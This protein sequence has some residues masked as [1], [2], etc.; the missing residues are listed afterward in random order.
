MRKSTTTYTHIFNLTKRQKE[1]LDLLLQGCTSLEQIAE[2]MFIEKIT[3]RTHLNDIYSKLGIHSLA[4]LIAYL[5]KEKLN[6]L[7]E[8]NEEYKKRE[9][10]K[11]NLKKGK[12]I[13]YV[14]ISGNSFA[15]HLHYEVLKDGVYLDPVDFFYASVTPDEYANIKFMASR[16]GQSL[17]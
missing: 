17:D 14:G 1:I 7:Q 4:G 5:Y 15:P 12:K 8:E 16:T 6:Q 13:A 11:N 9:A 3:V 10:D 2:K